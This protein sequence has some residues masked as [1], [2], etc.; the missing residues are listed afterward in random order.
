MKQIITVSPNNYGK[1]IFGIK[2]PII[3]T[4]D[5]LEKIVIDSCLKTVGEFHDK[6]VI[7]ITE[8]V[9]AIAQGN[10]VS[11]EEIQ[12]DIAN[13][14]PV[15]NHIMLYHPIQSRNR[16]MNIAKAIAGTPQIQHITIVL[17][18]PC[19]E[20]GNRILSEKVMLESK[21]NPYD[22]AFTS[23]E[24]YKIFGKP[25]HPFT[26]KDYIEE[27]QKACDEA[28]KEVDIIL[29]NNMELVNDFADNVLVCTIRKDQRT[30]ERNYFSQ[31]GSTVYDMSDILCNS[32]NGSGYSPEYGLYGSNMMAGGS[33]KLMPRDS[34]KFVDNLKKR[35]FDDFGKRIEALIYG[36][37]AF[38][39]PV[40]G[41]WEL[42]DP[43]S[44]LAATSGLLGTP[45]EIKLKYLASKYPDA[46]QEELRIILAR[47]KEEFLISDDITSEASLGTTPR[48]KTD[49]FASW[50]DLTTGS[51]DEQTPVVYAL[52]F[53]K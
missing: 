9:L 25:K 20:V 29:S 33:L 2:T 44:S 48:Q 15:A 49:L 38:K 8:A 36:D 31:L 19:D 4:G 23:D 16:F 6:A 17:S 51:G 32:V 10:Y 34:Q 43:V 22:D 53:L 1:M 5:D 52:G 14:F 41:I 37:G 27:F 50:A 46:N 39:D 45:K 7:G 30:L 13:K 35:I 42:A 26:G 47:E 24:F 40:G 28:G 21:V 18:F 11:A 3:R 12:I